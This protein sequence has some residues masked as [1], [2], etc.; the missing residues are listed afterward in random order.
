MSVSEI[1]PANDL[2]L[3]KWKR[4]WLLL[5]AL[6]LYLVSFALPLQPSGIQYGFGA[7]LMAWVVLFGILQLPNFFMLASLLLFRSKTRKKAAMIL[8]PLG[9][10]CLLIS[11]LLGDMGGVGIGSAYYV[12]LLS[13][14]L[15]VIACCDLAMFN[16]ATRAIPKNL[17]LMILAGGL[18]VLLILFVP[19]SQRR[20]RDAMVDAA[21]A[22]RIEI[23]RIAFLLGG[24]AESRKKSIVQ[25]GLDSPKAIEIA[26]E[27][28]SDR[29]LEFLV[30]AYG[31]LN[32]VER[33][34]SPLLYHAVQ[35]R[36]PSTIELL[37][38]HGADPQATEG[39]GLTPLHIAAVQ[40]DV[41]IMESLLAAGA[42]VDAQA[43]IGVTPLHYAASSG[44]ANAVRFL[45]NHGADPLKKD[46]ENRTPLDHA[47]RQIESEEA[48]AKSA[49]KAYDQA[50]VKRSLDHAKRCRDVVPLLEE[51]TH[52]K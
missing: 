17:S 9:W 12:W 15:V 42:P 1:A 23:A 27:R 4:S 36:K 28:G 49:E 38:K 21:F 51:F 32:H 3:P 7:F 40:G 44:R 18:L 5:L 6:A 19:W 37:L 35:S 29:V 13:Q 10:V 11:G 2:A 43:H 30:S 50:Q 31:D 45:L 41:A 8:L 46:R 47:Q 52:E 25:G 34:G 16:S 48:T 22:D 20:A 39:N 33:Y 24:R 14:V 26:C